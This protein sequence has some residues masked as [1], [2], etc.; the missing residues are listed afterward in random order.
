MMWEPDDRPGSLDLQK[1]V[2]EGG[3][4]AW[5]IAGAEKLFEKAELRPV[6]NF[7]EP[8]GSGLWETF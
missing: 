4:V 3:N 6:R 8:V 1:R 5:D 7:E 2:L